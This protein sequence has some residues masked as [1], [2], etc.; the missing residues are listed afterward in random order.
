MRRDNWKRHMKIHVDISLEDPEQICKSILKD[1]INYIP[2]K[3]ETS[4]YKEK[5]KVNDLHSEGLDEL[6][7][8]LP[9]DVDKMKLKNTILHYNH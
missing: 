2:N 1:I 4:M 9:A 5:S 3:D 8:P 6:H 7:K